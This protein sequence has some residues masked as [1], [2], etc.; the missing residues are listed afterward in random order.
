M[1]GTWC[2]RSAAATL[3]A[4]DTNSTY[5]RVRRRRCPPHAGWPGRHR[6]DPRG[7]A[8]TGT[9]GRRVDPRQRSAYLRHRD[10]TARSG[11]QRSRTRRRAPSATRRSRT[12]TASTASRSRSATARPT[13]NIATVTVTITPVERCAGGICRQPDDSRRHAGHGN[14][15]VPSMSMA[16][17]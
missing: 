9:S 15:D 12:R 1:A 8:A 14:A 11:R 7:H 10:R 6:H 16:R 17:R 13:S 5:G 2:S 3:V 4:D